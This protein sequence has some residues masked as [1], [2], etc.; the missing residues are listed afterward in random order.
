MVTKVLG[1]QTKNPDYPFLDTSR[2][3]VLESYLSNKNILQPGE[4]V[5][6]VTALGRRARNRVVRIITAERSLV[7]KQFLPWA[8]NGTAAPALEDRFRAEQQFH[9]SSRIAECPKQPVPNL[10]HVDARGLCMLFEDAGGESREN[11]AP[12]ADEAEGLAWFLVN[13]HHH[14]Q[15]VPGCAR[16]ENGGVRQWLASHLFADVSADDERHAWAARLQ[17]VSDPVRGYLREARLALAEDGLCLLHGDFLP[18]NWLCAEGRIR[19]VDTEFSFYGRPEFDAGSLL[20]GLLRA[21][22]DRATMRRVLA[23]LESGCVRYDARLTACFA[24]VQLADLLDVA[25]ASG[26]GPR[27]STASALLR[28]AVRA[29]ETGTLSGL[30]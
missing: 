4:R 6:E 13:L 14:T 12:D 28:R 30:G 9:R 16:H 22:C 27:G 3:D 1:Q 11:C 18:R 25:R 17:R 21:G 23:V 8:C 26:A 2:I 19:I 7:L 29:V 15:S 10:L 5:L 24:A 20:A